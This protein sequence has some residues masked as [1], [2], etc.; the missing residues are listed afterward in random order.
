MRS[1]NPSLMNLLRKS[2]IQRFRAPIFL[3]C[4]LC[5]L[6]VLPLSAS[7]V[8]FF[9]TGN[10]GITN[11]A[12]NTL[13]PHWTIT[14]TTQP[15]PPNTNVFVATGCSDVSHTNDCGPAPA[16]W[17]LNGTWADTAGGASTG[18]GGAWVSPFNDDPNSLSSIGYSYSYSE[19]FDLTNFTLASVTLSGFWAA[20]NCANIV[21]N[22]T[23]LTATDCTNAANAN[24]Y[25]PK[26][27]FTITNASGTGFIQ[28]INTITWVVKNF[29]TSAPDP[30]GLLVEV[31]GSTGNLILG[32]EPA[33]LFGVGL[34]L[35][36]VGL[37]YRRRR[38][39]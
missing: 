31:N 25:N 37:A 6:A 2:T 1:V 15:A 17:P 35:A 29:P 39:S 38:R 27:A 16:G 20:D 30:S 32:P 4:T 28:G 21:L 3:L 14:A 11:L 33:T 13:D 26:T 10:N 7:S 22:G 8:N 5:F 23:A 24:Q 12:G 34:G 9:G 36:V 18:T 19:T